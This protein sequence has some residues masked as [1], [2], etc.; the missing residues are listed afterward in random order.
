M[1]TGATGT[2]NSVTLDP[3][4]MADGV[5]TP[6]DV[7]FQG[8]TAVEYERFLD[9]DPGEWGS[10]LDC[11]AGPSSFAATDHPNT[12]VIAV[13]PAY[14]APIARLREECESN[15]DRLATNLPSLSDRFVWRFYESP[16]ERVS[17]LK[18]AHGRFLED[19][20]ANPSRY[21][22]AGLPEL[23]FR[24][25]S[26]ELAL[27]AH[28]LFMYEH[29]LGETF[30]QHAI[31]EL[32]RVS[33]DEVRVYPLLSLDGQPS[34]QVA[35]VMEWLETAGYEAE[36]RPVPFEFQPGADEMLVVLTE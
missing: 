9:I 22:A 12:D 30:H 24:T 14:M 29:Q 3:F 27:S 20:S 16:E 11:G 1:L 21:V 6:G 32:C 33:R 17:Y 35:D 13:D 34:E 23:P 2:V 4:A 18:E 15:V 26:F 8:R 19:V 10:I 28:F 36:R 25:N 7:A 31:A 5:A